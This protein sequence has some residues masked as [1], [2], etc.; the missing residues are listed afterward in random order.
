MKS[1]ITKYL[2]GFAIF[3]AYYLVIRNIENRVEAFRSLTN[4]GSKKA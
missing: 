4:I 3:A 2:I 1:S